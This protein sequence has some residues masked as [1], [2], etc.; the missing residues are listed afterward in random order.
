MKLIKSKGQN[1]ETDYKNITS[2][3]GLKTHTVAA[4]DILK[5]SLFKACAVRLL[6]KISRCNYLMMIQVSLLDLRTGG[7]VYVTADNIL[8]VMLQLTTYCTL[9]YS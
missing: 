6:N 1:I 7:G 5:K 4:L 8:H 2:N 3:S 9:C